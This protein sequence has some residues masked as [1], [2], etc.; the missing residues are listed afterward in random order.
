MAGV[1]YVPEFHHTLWTD[2]IDRVTAAGEN[3]FNVR[4]QA[5]EAEFGKIAQAA[6]EPGSVRSAHFELVAGTPVT[7]SL[8][9]GAIADITGPVVDVT[10][11]AP[12]LPLIS[13]SSTTPNAFFSVLSCYRMGSTATQL[14]PVFRV[15]NLTPGGVTIAI[16]ATPYVVRG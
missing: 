7:L 11:P 1:D 13:I 2:N 5:V 10:P 6:L 15:Q 4:F 14:T 16:K 3:G 9:T 8:N 12:A